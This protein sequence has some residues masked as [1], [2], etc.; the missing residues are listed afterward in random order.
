M[1]I[2][3]VSEFPE[4]Q[5]G[6]SVCVLALSEGS[7]GTYRLRAHTF[8]PAGERDIGRWIS[9]CP[10]TVT[11]SALL[12]VS[13]FNWT[14][15]MAEGSLDV[16]Q[17]L[18]VVERPVPMFPVDPNTGRHVHPLDMLALL[19]TNMPPK[20]PTSPETGASIDLRTIVRG[21]G[22]PQ[23]APGPS[24][25]QQTGFP[26]IPM[27]GQPGPTQPV[28]AGPAPG[29]PLLAGPAPVAP[30]QPGAANPRL[31]EEQQEVALFMRDLVRAMRSGAPVQQVRQAALSYFGDADDLDLDDELGDE[32]PPE[33]LEL[34]GQMLR[35]NPNLGE[36][37]ALDQAF[38]AYLAQ[39][40]ARLAEPANPLPALP[41]GVRPLLPGEPVP[42]HVDPNARAQ[43]D[44][45]GA[46]PNDAARLQRGWDRT[47]A[48]RARAEAH[49]PLPPGLRPAPAGV[50]LPEYEHPGQPPA[51]QPP[52]PRHPRAAPR[53]PQRVAVAGPAPQAAPPVDPGA[54]GQ[55]GPPLS[56]EEADRIA[57]EQIDAAQKAAEARLARSVA[58]SEAV[59]VEAEAEAEAARKKAEAEAAAAGAH[60]QGAPEGEPGGG[61]VNFDPN[62]IRVGSGGQPPAEG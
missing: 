35:L 9:D 38:Q 32:Y 60:Q 17:V 25:V 57:Q 43:I 44:A 23:G 36:E 34:A 37:A 58:R 33:V 30:V 61:D 62:N 11:E 59:R 27:Q 15:Q 39:T 14:I 49:S 51:Q 21:P 24:P 50:P 12:W 20:N 18:E 26:Q 16:N 7:A 1:L 13:R 4:P 31:N 2:A 5:Q 6:E 56:R 54:N 55:H 52:A 40:P 19:A 10:L 3:Q 48:M 22:Q 53:Q 41:P 8:G 45:L 46:N 47:A 42:G 29:N 28:L